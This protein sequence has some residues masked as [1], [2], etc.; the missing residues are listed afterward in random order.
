MKFTDYEEMAIIFNPNGQVIDIDKILSRAGVIVLN[1]DVK[2]F[3]RIEKDFSPNVAAPK[4]VVSPVF[5]PA[6]GCVFY[7]PPMATGKDRT[8]VL[9]RLLCYAIIHEG[10]LADTQKWNTKAQPETAID[11]VDTKRAEVFARAILMPLPQFREVKSSLGHCELGVSLDD[12]AEMFEVDEQQ[13][14][15]RWKDLGMVDC[16]VQVGH[17]EF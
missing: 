6:A 10:Y 12:M 5:M 7:I 3:G 17:C 13:V 16:K 2:S 11:I 8:F 9:T 14:L 4:L 1:D 15:A